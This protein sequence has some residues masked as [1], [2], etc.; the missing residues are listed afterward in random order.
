MALFNIPNRASNDKVIAKK[1]NSA[2][3]KAPITVKGSGGLINRIKSAIAL[4]EKNLGKYR[5]E[6]VL[7]QDEDTLIDYID[8]AIDNH[9]ISIDTETTGLDPLLDE[10]AGVCIYTPNKKSAYIPINHISYMT[11]NKIDGQLSVEFIREQFNRPIKAKIDIIMFNATF[12]IRVMRNKVGC[13]DIYCTWDCQL[14][15]RLLNENEES[16]ALKKLHQKYVLDGKA[17]AFTFEDL[18]KGIPFTLIPLQTALLYAAHDPII[19]YELYEYQKQ[20]LR[21]DIDRED[22]K[23]IYWVFENIEMPLVR[24]VA[25][26][27][28]AGVKFDFAY[29]EKLKEKY[30]KL[31]QER[32]EEFH[33]ICDCDY[34]SAIG[35]YR[36]KHPD[37]KLDNPINIASPTQLAILLYDIMGCDLFY[38]KKK[39]QNTRSTAEEALSNLDNDVAKAILDYR[40]FSTIVSTFIDKLP[41]C[42]NP[43]DGRIHCKFNQYGADTGRMSSQDPNL[44]NIPSHITDIRQM[45][46]ASDGCVLMSSDFSQQEPKALAA[47]C[48]KD[49]DSQ[50][51]DTF[52]QGK[53]LYS[54]IASKSFNVPYED[55]KEFNPDG[56][57]NKAGKNRRTQAKSILLGVLYGRG[58][59]SIAEQ[60]KTSE[61]K[62]KAIKESVFNAFPAIRKFEKDSK[63]MAYYE[64]YVT[65]VC[66]RKR[67]LPDMQLNQYDFKWSDDAPICD[68]V[69]DFE[70]EDTA[71]PIPKSRQKYY[72]DKLKFCRFNQ[73]QKIFQEANK[74]GIWI[75]DN[76]K[77]IADAERQCVN[78]RIQ[79]SAA[80]LTK[81]AMIDMSNNERLK[82]LGFKLLIP[83]HDEVIAECPEKN[84]KECSELLAQVMSNAA[85]KILEM[86]IKCD[87]VVSRSWYGKEIQL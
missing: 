8:T 82:E 1:V 46:V 58:E 14:A 86:P 42:V 18:F 48:R 16:N 60:L 64:G 12:D 87:V 20:Y 22:L 51:Y 43:N 81:L 39:K 73:K 85:Q 50:L 15:A 66:G 83:V 33:N 25:D 9:I 44:Q 47:L 29:N 10:I 23:R 78:A 24:V 31:L 19:T 21:P 41:D 67:R 4:V 2:T 27:E 36:E 52:I 77:K 37:V 35:E 76:S 38:D 69:L 32:E 49:G 80:D 65:T 54:E 17:D 3:V 11:N 55:C 72:L 6:Y 70:S 28:D 40:E 34:A 30:H 5:E 63:E 26:M 53:D 79:G 59:K 45:F 62:A 13:K 84:A 68:D 71:L 56:S 74:E 57:T 61:D 75:I 7:I